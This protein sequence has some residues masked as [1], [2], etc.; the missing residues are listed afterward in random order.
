MPGRQATRPVDRLAHFHLE[1]DSQ[2][3]GDAAQMIAGIIVIEA[4]RVMRP[5]PGLRSHAAPEAVITAAPR[6]VAHRVEEGER[7][8]QAEARLHRPVLRL[9][10]DLVE[11][12]QGKEDQPVTRDS[13]GW[14]IERTKALSYMAAF[15]VHA[16]K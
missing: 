8:A 3:L 16:A 10:H 13:H 1:I 11:R 14:N 7:E 6:P 12:A 5:R 9:I 4:V 15:M 2:R